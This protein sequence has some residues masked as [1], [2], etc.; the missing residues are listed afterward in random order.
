[1]LSELPLALQSTAQSEQ[2]FH[3]ATD[4]AFVPAGCQ[5]TGYSCTAVDDAELL[6]HA[7]R[8]PI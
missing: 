1:M 4:T 6:F 5:G 8:A 7:I 3:P 2:I